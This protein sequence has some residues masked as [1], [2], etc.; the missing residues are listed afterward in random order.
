LDIS[1]KNTHKRPLSRSK[2]KGEKNERLRP[3]RGVQTH[4]F[5]GGFANNFFSCENI[6]C[7]KIYEFI[8]LSHF[9][10]SDSISDLKKPTI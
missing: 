7:A 1:S 3:V 10:K 2:E 8:V 9:L 6:F 5:V 4:G